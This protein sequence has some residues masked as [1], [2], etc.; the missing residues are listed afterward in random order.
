M[1]K[2]QL[3]LQ[4]FLFTKFIS[5]LVDNNS[6]SWNASILELERLKQFKYQIRI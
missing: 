2:K 3:T 5:T 6:E 1:N 4:L